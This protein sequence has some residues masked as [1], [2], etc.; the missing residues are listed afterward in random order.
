MSC[1]QSSPP[2]V[3]ACLVS[4]QKVLQVRGVCSYGKLNHWLGA[5]AAEE[6]RPSIYPDIDFCKDPGVI[7]S[8]KRAPELRWITG[9]FHWAQTIQRSREY[10]YFPI[11]KA[12]VDAGDYKD[13]SFIG[14]VNT[15]L[16]GSPDDIS[17]RTKTFFNALRAFN[18][19]SVET[20]STG[21]P[22]FTFCGVDFNDAGTKCTPCETNIDCT[23]L[24]LCHA[25][26]IRCDPS[27]AG[28]DATGSIEGV[29]GSNGTNATA[30]TFTAD[31]IEG[32][33]TTDPAADEPPAM[34]EMT[35][36]ITSTT[37]YCGGSWGDAATNC[38]SAC[39]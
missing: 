12:F 32:A 17:R 9:M 1:F 24:E 14:M 29:A 20:N 22:E 26:V 13:G 33:N 16:G 38:V 31:S 3:S 34:T 8:D 21:T 37:N 18:L 11:L 4:Y 15:M 25:D 35:M 19:I 10:N 30:N 39:K 7:C 6:G 5:K 28:V 27:I 23:G 36:P 2:N